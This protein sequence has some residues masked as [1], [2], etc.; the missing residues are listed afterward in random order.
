MIN[1]ILKKIFGSRNDRLLRK[2]SHA[3]TAINALEP[4]IQQLRRCGSARAYR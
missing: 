4:Q 1:S 2:Y 3:V